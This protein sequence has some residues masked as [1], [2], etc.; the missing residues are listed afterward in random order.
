VPSED[1]VTERVAATCVAS[2]KSWAEAS[3]TVAALVVASQLA[4]AVLTSGPVSNTLA[5]RARWHVAPQSGTENPARC[6]GR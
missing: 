2:T 3:S 5:M 4:I 1:S 6:V